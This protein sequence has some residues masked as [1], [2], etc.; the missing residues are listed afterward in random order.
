[1][2]FTSG[3]NVFPDLRIVDNTPAAYQKSMAAIYDTMNKM[4][5][6]NSKDMIMC[7]HEEVPGSDDYDY[8]ASLNITF[9]KISREATSLGLSI[10]IRDTLKSPRNLNDTYY[11]FRGLNVNNIFMAPTT[12]HL[13]DD[14]YLPQQISFIIMR[15][16]ILLL[17]APTYDL[18]N[19]LYSEN[20]PLTALTTNGGDL[21]S[22]YISMAQKYGL[23]MVYDG[24]YKNLD[25]EYLD[26]K[27]F[28][29]L[30]DPEITK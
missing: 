17:N 20:A 24:I 25:D 19:R 23:W 3:L 8:W 22:Q 2:D 15:S 1:V 7:L 30:A 14:E 28:A 21:T 18:L 12:A 26:V 13:I 4:P 27:M 5:F 10:H 6:L 9:T 16:K 11:W 29:S